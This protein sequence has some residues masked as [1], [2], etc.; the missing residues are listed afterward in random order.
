[1]GLEGQGSDWC[2][3]GRFMVLSTNCYLLG[4][5]GMTFK[6]GCIIP[7]EAKTGGRVSLDDNIPDPWLGS[8]GDPVTVFKFCLRI[9][10]SEAQRSVGNLSTSEP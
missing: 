10:G 1:M 3:L 5:R 6:T 7:H 9:T 2:H 8:G 4:E